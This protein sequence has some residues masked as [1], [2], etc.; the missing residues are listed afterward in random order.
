MSDFLYKKANYHQVSKS[1]EKVLPKE[2]FKLHFDL[3]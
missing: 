2:M 3:G 1:M